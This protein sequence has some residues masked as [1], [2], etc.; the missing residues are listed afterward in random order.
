MTARAKS[1]TSFISY[2]CSR[3]NM[4]EHPAIEA[5]CTRWAKLANG[6]VGLG[7]AVH[8]DDARKVEGMK[9]GGRYA[10]AIVEIGDDEQPV[11]VPVETPTDNTPDNHVLETNGSGVATP[12][13]EP[14]R[15]RNRIA[16][17]WAAIKDARFQKWMRDHHGVQP[18]PIMVANKMRE[19]F[20]VTS[21][22]ELNR[23]GP[24]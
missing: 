12:S 21:F 11:K 7:F 6:E 5:R 10:L 8:I 22:N 3:K 18:D 1:S 9:P 4:S 23:E 13:H 20:K 24:A 15:P 14:L 16:G 2:S 17:A 19:I